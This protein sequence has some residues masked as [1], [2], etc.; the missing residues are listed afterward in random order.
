MPL[1]PLSVPISPSGRTSASTVN[2]NP[3]PASVPLTLPCLSC[4][5]VS[6]TTLPCGLRAV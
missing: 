1:S 6:V 5:S 3:W 4:L 2:V